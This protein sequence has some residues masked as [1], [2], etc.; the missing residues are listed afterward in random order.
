VNEDKKGLKNKKEKSK[1]KKKEKE[2]F[3]EVTTTIKMETRSSKRKSLEITPDTTAI[4]PASK[5]LRR[6]SVS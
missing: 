3:I 6:A 1:I 2:I 5:K 4:A